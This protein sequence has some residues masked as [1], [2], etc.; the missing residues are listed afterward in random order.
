MSTPNSAGQSSSSPSTPLRQLARLRLRLTAW[1]AATFVVILVLLGTG[2]FLVV[3][4]QFSRQLAHSLRDATTEIMRA[5]R[6]REM[7]QAAAH[8]AV[9]DAVDELHIPDRALY[10]FDSTG[11][12][13]K[14]PD[15]LPWIASAVRA[16]A[17]QGT[18][19]ATTRT[20]DERTLILHAESFRLERGTMMVAVAVADRVVLQDTYADLIAAFGGAAAIAILLV[21]AGGW[22][23]VRKSTAP[24]E[25]NIEHMRRFVADAAHELRTPV[26]V[27]RSRAEVTLMQPR[28]AEVYAS[29]LRGIGAEAGRLAAIVENLFTLARADAGRPIERTRVFLDDIVLD[30]TDAAHAMAQVKGVTVSV[31]EFEEAPVI[32]DPTLLRQLVMILLDNAVKFTASGGTVRV[33]VGAR[34]DGRPTFSIE[35]T[36]RGIPAEQL[37][38]VFERFYRGDRTRGGGR[39]S[40][41]AEPADGAGLGLSIAKWIADMHDAEIELVSEAER[42]TRAT[43]RFAAAAPAAAAPSPAIQTPGVSPESATSV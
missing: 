19:D 37:P 21:A 40:S 11:R 4:H 29:A 31:A 42:G 8:G 25:R 24:I 35:D 17:T 26:T 33:R 27:L 38:R 34:P 15:A 12:P 39:D 9:V 2:L 7:E 32:G 23:L 28:D 41:A 16:A 14:G 43:V 22:L 18:A 3:R 6:I 5:A 13:V 30:A 36:G 20:L 10:L 1:Y